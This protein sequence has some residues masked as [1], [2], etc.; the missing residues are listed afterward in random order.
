MARDIE[1]SNTRVQRVA[2][3]LA[4]DPSFTR[5]AGLA[6]IRMFEDV[7]VG[8]INQQ[9]DDNVT[10]SH[11][12]DILQDCMDMVH[13]HNLGNSQHVLMPNPHSDSSASSQLM[14]QANI[15]VCKTLQPIALMADGDKKASIPV[16]KKT[17]GDH[18]R[19]AMRRDLPVVDILESDYVWA[20][21][22]TA[23]NVSCH[24]IRWRKNA[25]KKLAIM[26]LCTYEKSK[27]QSSFGGLTGDD[28]AQV[29]A[30]R[31]IPL[32]LK[33]CKGDIIYGTLISCELNCDS[34]LLFGLDIQRALG[35]RFDPVQN[36][37]ERYFPDHGWV[38]LSCA[39]CPS[40]LPCVRIDHLDAMYN[41][42]D[43]KGRTLADQKSQVFS[44]TTLMP[45]VVY[46][47]R[48]DEMLCLLYTSPSPRD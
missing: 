32:L 43:R 38:E 14:P 47:A 39:Q 5:Q 11:L 19:D 25:D 3:K 35:L 45:G 12:H 27:C 36:K 22:D 8:L 10:C 9:T 44:C 41:Y 40:G 6:V 13:Q 26:G 37:L 4:T 15:A 24:G 31:C 21:I 29:V 2:S 1:L 20:I 18:V 23:C 34:N 30:K 33:E 7:A 42:L 28:A 46:N 48:D 17:A 16:G